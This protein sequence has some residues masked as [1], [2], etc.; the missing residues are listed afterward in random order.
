[1]SRAAFVDTNVLVYLFDASAPTKRA[2]AEALLES[3][4]RAGRLR[5]STQVLQEFFV[6]STKPRRPLLGA[7][8]A[9]AAL[10]R[11]AELPLVSVSPAGLLA[12]ADRAVRT[13]MHLYDAMIV[14]AALMAGC[15]VLYSEDLQH[16]QVIDGVRIENPFLAG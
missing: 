5:L 3:L 15:E 6:A 14:E 8:A 1:M 7:A 16:G 9:L 4:V 10:Q 12:A 2:R 13:G 11:F